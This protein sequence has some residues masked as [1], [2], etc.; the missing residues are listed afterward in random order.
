MKTDLYFGTIEDDDI[1]WRKELKDY[2]DDDD[3]NDIDRPTDP[4]VI[5]MLG[6]DPDKEDWDE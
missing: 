2:P 5:Q 4:D 6:F 3:E 1:D